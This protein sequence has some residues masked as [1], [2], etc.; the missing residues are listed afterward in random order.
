MIVIAVGAQMPAAWAQMKFEGLERLYFER[1]QMSTPLAKTGLNLAEF[2]PQKLQLQ[3]QEL[4]NM[5]DGAGKQE[6]RD[7]EF[8]PV[9]IRDIAPPADAS[10]HRL[11]IRE[12]VDAQH[13][14]ISTSYWALYDEGQ[15]VDV[16]KY[17]SGAGSADGK[18]LSNMSLVG[19]ASP[20]KDT[21][22]L[23]TYGDM[24]RPGGYWWVLGKELVF[25]MKEDAISFARVRNTWGIF[26]SN[27]EGRPGIYTEQEANGRF[28]KRMS[29]HV[30]RKIQKTC[31]YK[32]PQMD[33]GWNSDWV[34]LRDVA[35]CVTS[36]ERAE[37][38][39]RA[40]DEPSF[41]ERQ[42]GKQ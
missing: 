33:D 2:F 18:A 27:I 15:R 10:Q 4:L 34:V 9:Y 20:E 1:V 21:L 5:P 37:V 13:P 12:V 17:D 28:V 35:Q 7:A 24:F 36:K 14:R 38:S 26:K 19:I 39:Y 23:R 30:S 3:N 25:S 40:L 11:I 8:G 16:W 41:M 29:D 42:K 32:D 22:V 6:T 31:G